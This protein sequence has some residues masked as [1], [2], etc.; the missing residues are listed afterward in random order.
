MYASKL[1]LSRLSTS[2]LP[3]PLTSANASPSAVPKHRKLGPVQSECVATPWLT[4]IV[5]N[6]LQP[7]KKKSTR[8]SPV[9][10]PTN[11][12]S[13]EL[14]RLGAFTF[15]DSIPTVNRFLPKPPLP[16]LIHNPDRCGVCP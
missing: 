13:F 12:I 3:S 16:L 11:R 15:D 1:V 8:P 10:S 4:H 5:P 2:I 9:R 14:P 7:R 6:P